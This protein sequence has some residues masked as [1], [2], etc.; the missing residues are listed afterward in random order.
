MD[1]HGA[2]ALDQRDR[3]LLAAQVYWTLTAAGI[4]GPFQLL[5]DGKALDDRFPG[6]W[7][8]ENVAALNPQ[9]PAT[10]PTELNAVV[11]GAL[12][13]VS[14]TGTNPVPGYFGSS[15]TLRTAALSYDRKAVAAVAGAVRGSGPLQ[16]LVGSYGGTESP[17][18]G[19]GS[20]TRPTWS[21]DGA[22]VWAVL[23]GA[24]VVRAPSSGSAMPAIDVDVATIL[25][26]GRAITEFRLSRDGVRAAL[27]DNGKVYVAIVAVGQDGRYA[28]TKP[29]L[30]PLETGAH[31]VSLAWDD[32]GADLLV[33]EDFDAPLVKVSVDGSSVSAFKVLQNLVPPVVVVNVTPQVDYVQDSRTVLYLKV[34]DT[35][36]DNGFWREVAILAGTR[37]TP[38]LPG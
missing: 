16:L 24:R 17:V 27:I 37:A 33:S 20:I 8:A 10:G 9:P 7:P 5:A 38:V 11:N 3:E 30:I 13:S 2:G 26:L 6:D 36:V 19:G 21:P 31:A 12:V 15:A 29:R 18:A 1:F 23:D 34:D 32:G 35:D 28:L 4:A 22:W 25:P 14:D